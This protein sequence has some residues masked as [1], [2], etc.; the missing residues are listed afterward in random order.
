MN[1]F[2]GMKILWIFF[3]FIT[4]FGLYYGVISMHFRVFFLRARYRMWVILGLVK[5]QIFFW[6]LDILIFFFGEW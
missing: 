5:F 2:L 1:N 3:G 6:V 4:I